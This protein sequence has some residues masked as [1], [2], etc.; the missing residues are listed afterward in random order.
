MP[1]TA[2]PRAA[3]PP[4]PPSPQ[5]FHLHPLATTAR[6]QGH[7]VHSQ[8]LPGD[9][10]FFSFVQWIYSQVFPEANGGGAKIIC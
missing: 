9:T 1:P 10:S 6:A 2:P 8:P 5:G 4:A 7:R 3:M